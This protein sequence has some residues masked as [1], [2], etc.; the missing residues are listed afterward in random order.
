VTDANLLLGFLGPESFLGGKMR[1]DPEL[2]REAV[3]RRVA[4]PLGLDTLDAAAGMIRI[5]NTHMEISLRLAFHERGQDPRKFVL[6]AFGGAGPLHAA[7]LARTLQIPRVLVPLYPGITSAMGLLQTQVKHFYLQ[8]SVG[9]LSRFPLDR[10][11]SLYDQLEAR[12]LEDAR[13]EGFSP[14][15]VQ[16]TRQLDLRYLH[17]GYQITVECPAQKLTEEDRAPLKQAFDRLHHRLYGQSAAEEEAEVVTLRLLAEIPVPRL[18]LPELPP[19]D[20][21]PE[22]ALRGERLLYDLAQSRFATAR[23]YERAKLQ[24]GDR[25]GGPAVIEQ[26]DAT[27]V[28]LAGQ[29]ARVDRFGNLVIDAGGAG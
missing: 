29:E 10:L 17:Q 11:N 15:A 2:A 3:K 18:S 19:G 22:R 4:E 21:I 13:A 7:H 27:T 5:V 14:T 26:F 23:V 20:G 1:V 8:S 28:V 25:L 6:I 9:P 24:S 12:A 16:I